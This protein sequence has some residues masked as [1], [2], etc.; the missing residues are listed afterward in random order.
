MVHFLALIAITLST[1]VVAP[2]A[3]EWHADYGKA[4]AATR[5]DDRPLL[6]VLDAPKTAAGKQQLDTAGEQAKLLAAYQLCHVD[7]STEY[8][9]R[10][11]KVFNA[12]QFPFTAII[13]KTGSI[14]LHKKQ[15]ALT[16]AQWSKTLTTY[17]S[18][19]RSTL[20]YHSTGYRGAIENSGYYSYPSSGTMLADPSYCPSCQ[21]NAQQNF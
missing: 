4:L 19:E 18:G 17:K 9:K 21:R 10:V 12:K 20:R 2:K 3:A 5:T 13:D 15:G 11:A 16:D 1:A 6:I 14:V 8:G 7:I